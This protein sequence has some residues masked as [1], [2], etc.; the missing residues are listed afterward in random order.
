ML[1]LPALKTFLSFLR[2]IHARREKRSPLATP[3]PAQGQIQPC[4]FVIASLLSSILLGTP[5]ALA[6]PRGYVPPSNPTSPTTSTTGGGTRGGCGQQS[7]I[8]L[9]VLAPEK[10][11]GQTVSNRPTFAWYV[12]EGPSR[13]LEFSLYEVRANQRPRLLYRV[14]MES[15][16]RLMTYRLPETVAAL[17]AGQQYFWQVRLLCNPARPSSALVAGATVEVV[18]RPA[19]L[20]AAGV[21]GDRQL[22][23]RQLAQLSLWYDALD[24]ALQSPANGYWLQL[25]ND[26]AQA[27]E[28]GTSRTMGSN[29]RDRLQ[30][31]ITLEQGTGQ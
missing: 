16:P 30:R 17:T 11:V 29:Q 4:P 20:A 5:L 31:I 19:E 23:A 9:T 2:M 10:Y 22:Q 13:P 14:P 21:G 15:T 3:A 28:T 27:E 18:A 8:T 6:N 25:L 12:P 24:L 7:A 1:H 26:L